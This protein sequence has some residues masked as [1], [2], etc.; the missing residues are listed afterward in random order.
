VLSR[1]C[2]ALS[3]TSIRVK[4]SLSSKPR[5]ELTIMWVSLGVMKEWCFS[6]IWDP[7]EP[8]KN[9]EQWLERSWG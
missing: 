7:D 4:F 9:F 3:S 5:R 6:D 8:Q 2:L 1:R